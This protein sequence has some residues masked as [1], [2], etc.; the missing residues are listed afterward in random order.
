[1]KTSIRIARPT[2][3]LERALHFYCNGLGFEILDSYE[4]QNGFNGL[5]VGHKDFSYH[6]EF[7]HRSGAHQL[8][9]P[10]KEN[11]LVFFI[12]DKNAWKE[13]VERMLIVGY[14]PVDSLNAY[15]DEN[16]KTFEDDNGYRIVLQNGAWE[17]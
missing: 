7:T 13:A 2:D 4:N 3:K 11:I 15:W 6:L 16:G 1:M 12:Q 10:S 8:P 14:Q 17:N 5:I 9:T